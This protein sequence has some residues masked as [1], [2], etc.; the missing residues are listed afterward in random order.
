VFHIGDRELTDFKWIEMIQ[1]SGPPGE[2]CGPGACGMAYAALRGGFQWT[3]GRWRVIPPHVQ[4]WIA[5]D[6]IV[7]VIREDHLT[8]FDASYRRA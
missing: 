6:P 2:R 8:S 3:P 1:L 4:G 5:P 7:V